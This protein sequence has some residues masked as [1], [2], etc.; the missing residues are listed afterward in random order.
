MESTNS[1]HSAPSKLSLPAAPAVRVSA[2]VA[3]DAGISGG[4]DVVI[5]SPSGCM[6]GTA[7]V[8]PGLADG[9]VWAPHGWPEQ[10]VNALVDGRNIDPLTGLPIMTGLEISIR[11]RGDA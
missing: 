10:G 3:H 4:D 6:F 11:P 7:E 9:T 8:D 5:T 2:D 1:V